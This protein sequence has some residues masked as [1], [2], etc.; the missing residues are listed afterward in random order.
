MAGIPAP[1]NLLAEL[2]EWEKV[3]EM[4]GLRLMVVGA[5][6]VIGGEVTAAAA[7]RRVRV[8]VAGRDLDRLARAAQRMG[9]GQGEVFDAYDLESCRA[10][11]ARAA[12]RIGSLNAVLVAVGA[13]AFGRTGEVPLAVQEHLMTVN[14]LAPMAVL[15]G[16]LPVVGPGGAIGALT[17]V[18]VDRPFPG[19]A[20]YRTSKAVLAAWLE[21]VWAEYRR[22]RVTVLDAR[23][24]HL[25][26]G[27]TL[28]PL[29]GTA[30][31]LPPGAARETWVSAVL[32]G[33]LHGAAVLR[34]E[35]PNARPLHSPGPTDAATRLRG[36][37]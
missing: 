22:E 30:P 16:A 37:G 21:A 14:T 24:P 7:A 2:A 28:R 34:P 18:V 29:S 26:T 9:A 27:F 32:D 35:G 11:A 23:L 8:A 20:A 31:P 25:D 6:G 33:L 4:N 12:E 3:V 13:I 5:T 36:G 15:E 17:G 1:A 19:T 10:L